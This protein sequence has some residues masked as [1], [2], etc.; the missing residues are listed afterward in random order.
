MEPEFFV[1]A[2]NRWINSHQ[3]FRHETVQIVRLIIHGSV[4][5]NYKSFNVCLKNCFKFFVDVVL[6]LKIQMYE[7]TEVFMALVRIF[8]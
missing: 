1:K 6:F 7:L 2:N 5:C 8:F 3:T 4:H